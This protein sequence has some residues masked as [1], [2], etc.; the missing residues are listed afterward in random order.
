[1]L[2]STHAIIH[3]AP[4]KTSAA[5]VTTGSRLSDSEQ[6]R[7]A[8]SPLSNARRARWRWPLW[9]V[10]AAQRNRMAKTTTLFWKAISP[11]GSGEVKTTWKYGIGGP[12]R[13]CRAMAPL[14]T[15][16][17]P[18]MGSWRQ[19]DRGFLSA[20]PHPPHH[21]RARGAPSARRTTGMHRAADE[22]E[23]SPPLHRASLVGSPRV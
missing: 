15:T 22:P 20:A 18:V 23:R 10:S 5:A 6:A 16:E 17:D 11:A 2:K 13:A 19:P 3:T 1:M 7:I 21:H 8:A 14:P 12:L 9:S 4:A